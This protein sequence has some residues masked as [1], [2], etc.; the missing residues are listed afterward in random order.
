MLL[1]LVYTSSNNIFF[2]AKSNVDLKK[3]MHKNA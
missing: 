1:L 2:Y 3:N